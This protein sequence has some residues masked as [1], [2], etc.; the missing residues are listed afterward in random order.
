MTAAHSVS[1]HYTGGWD[2]VRLQ[3]WAAQ[4]RQ[5][6][7]APEVTLGLVFLTPQFF[8]MAA[9]VLELLRLHA[10]IPLLVGCSARGL[11]VNESELEA[12]SGLVVQL[13]HLPG[14]RA[15]ALHITQEQLEAIESPEDWHRLSRLTPAAVRGWLV[16]AD[17]FQF[18]GERWLDSWNRAFPGVPAVGGLAA[19]PMTEQRTQLYLDGRV[20][21]EGALA[22]GLT[23]AVRLETV[24]SQG[25]TPIGVPWTITKSERHYIHQ[26]GNRPAYRVL[27][28]TFES[29][30]REEQVLTKGNLFVGFAGDE[31]REEFQ[32]GDFLVR[33]VL[34]A[35][36]QNGVI[37]VGALPR[38]GQT[39]QFHRRDS[40]TATEDLIAVLDRARA[41]LEGRTVL[42]G[43]LCICNGRGRHLFGKPD[44]DA[45]LIQ[46][47]LGPLP[48]SGFF[49]NGEI[50]PVGGRNFLHG[51]TGALGLLVRD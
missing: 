7:D 12:D 6:L 24:I 32:R 45:G 5:R 9:E 23:G 31:Y 41:R 11:V 29:M 51:Y 4:L 14:A 30:P 15:Q 40:V 16:F 33:N 28:E 46:E 49:C 38:P 26:I 39:V 20:L 22:I 44:H 10:R 1:A 36:P 25:C 50:G 2:E 3:R 18:D 37:A 43:L 13:F 48:V 35:D 19:G 17:P 8:P 34:G 47:Q 42:G 27:V 21:E